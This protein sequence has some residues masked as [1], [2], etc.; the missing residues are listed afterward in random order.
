MRSLLISGRSPFS[1]FTYLLIV[2]SIS[3]YD[4][5]LTANYAS[6][7]ST[8]EEN[9][10]GRWIMGLNNGPIQRIMDPPNLGLFLLLKALG[11]LLVLVTMYLLYDKYRRVGHP[12]AL[13]V[14]VAQI[15]L[16]V[17]LTV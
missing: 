6:S 17:Y 8:M 14:S 11:T 9:P 13:G 7:L 10:L 4:W 15:V 5:L 12:V 16:A 3:T 1:I 2:G